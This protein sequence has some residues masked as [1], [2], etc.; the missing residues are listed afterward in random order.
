[1]HNNCIVIYS[2]IYIFQII[3][4]LTDT[5]LMWR[6]QYPKDTYTKRTLFLKNLKIFG[7]I[8]MI[9]LDK[10]LDTWVKS[11]CSFKNPRMGKLTYPRRRFTWKWTNRNRFVAS[12]VCIG[13]LNYSPRAIIILFASVLREC[14]VR[15]DVNPILRGGRDLGEASGTGGATLR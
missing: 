8:W 3:F 5:I 11:F 7:S 14:P 9:F 12:R 2:Y 6:A 15:E 13:S 1:M 4:S 10:F